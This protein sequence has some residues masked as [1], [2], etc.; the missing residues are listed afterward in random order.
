M[1]QFIESLRLLFGAEP[2]RLEKEDYTPA[3]AELHAFKQTPEQKKLRIQLIKE[4]F[5]NKEKSYKWKGR[6]WASII[7]INLM[8]IVSFHF[9]VQLV[10]GALTASRFVGFHMADLN[11]ALQVVLAQKEILINL[12]IGVVTVGLLWWFVGGRSF[13]SWVCPYHLLAELAEMLHLKLAD[14]KVV[15]DHPLHRGTRTVLY[16]VFALLALVTGY[17][18]FETISPVG[19]VSRSLIYGGGIAVAWVA[20]LLLIE[21][22]YIRRFWCRY[23]CPIGFTY[24]LIGT[25]SPVKV[26]YKLEHCL[27]EGEC[28]KVCMVPHVLEMTKKNRAE[29]VHMDIGADCTRCGM[30]VDACPTGA[31]TFRLKGLGDLL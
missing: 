26:Q 17:T 13:C 31:L 25:T 5:D 18:V 9:D 8:F 15:S 29:D 7:L 22:F 6:R 11:S 27:H 23:I 30:C 21:I 10:E 1:R 20:I 3:A 4:E 16:V 2:R 19:I 24:G 12:V 28:R 14:K